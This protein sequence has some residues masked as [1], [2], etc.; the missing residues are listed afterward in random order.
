M[1]GV[2]FSIVNNQPRVAEWVVKP[3]LECNIFV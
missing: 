2:G 1:S 3:F